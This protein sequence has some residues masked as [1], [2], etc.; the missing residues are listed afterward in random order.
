MIFHVSLFSFAP[1]EHRRRVMYACQGKLT[2]SVCVWGGNRPFQGSIFPGPIEAGGRKLSTSGRPFPTPFETT[3][4]C[5]QGTMKVYVTVCASMPVYGF[6]DHMFT[7]NSP[8]IWAG[9]NSSSSHRKDHS[10]SG[11]IRHILNLNDVG[12]SDPNLV[13]L[14]WWRNPVTYDPYNQLHFVLRKMCTSTDHIHKLWLNCVPLGAITLMR[15]YLFTFSLIRCGE[16]GITLGCSQFIVWLIQPVVRYKW[17]V[18]ISS[19]IS[20]E[21]QIFCWY[22][23]FL[24]FW[25]V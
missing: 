3:V 11:L 2:D 13:S 16:N 1:Q 23:C 7:F 5:A 19:M 22:R 24:E 8:H 10:L 9:S 18:F 4:L 21:P 12:V 17:N 6:L 14:L 25:L 15:S 20:T